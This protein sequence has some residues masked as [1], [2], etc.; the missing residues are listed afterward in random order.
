MDL[1]DGGEGCL[2][3]HDRFASCI[4]GTL[5]LALVV[6]C[7]W[8]LPRKHI[9]WQSFIH[10]RDGSPSQESHNFR[11]LCQRFA[12]QGCK[13]FGSDQCDMMGGRA[14]T[15]SLASVVKVRCSSRQ[16]VHASVVLELV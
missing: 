3:V 11:K 1:D 10:I 5:R 4:I 2:R 6:W 7:D 14:T 12:Y 8:Q 13:L 15:V 16:S 9:S